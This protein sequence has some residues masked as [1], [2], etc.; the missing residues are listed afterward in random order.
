MIE[1]KRHVEASPQDVFAVL[2]DGW[3]YS[4]WVVGAS[5]IRAVDDHWPKP[6]AKIHHSVGVWPALLNDDSEVVD[7]VDGH[8]LVLTAR[9]WPLGEA[10]VYL[11]LEDD[12]DGGCLVRMQEDASH[13]PGKLV[14][15]PLRQLAIA[16]R[17]TESLRRLALLAEGGAQRR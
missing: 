1:V 4:G 5:R 9:G 10:T 2:A 13:G 15:Q 17:N 12:G 8:R 11:E 7:V 16:P 3:L 6:G 14:P